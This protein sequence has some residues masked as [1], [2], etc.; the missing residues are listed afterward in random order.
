MKF[1]IQPVMSGSECIKQLHDWSHSLSPILALD[2][3]VST[4]HGSANS[5]TNG[6]GNYHAPLESVDNLNGSE[7]GEIHDDR[8]APLFLNKE[9]I[10]IGMYT[11]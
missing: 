6:F 8:S 10:M 2:S 4:R 1:S 5:L 9:L 11:H 7:S 3:L